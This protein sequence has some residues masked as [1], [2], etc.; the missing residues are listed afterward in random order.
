MMNYI[1]PVSFL[2]EYMPSVIFHNE[3][4]Q[5]WYRSLTRQNLAVLLSAQECLEAWNSAHCK[6]EK[7]INFLPQMK[8]YFREK[9]KLQI[10]HL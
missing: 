8:G 1:V 9:S 3:L 6:N 10:M 2:A 7:I 4:Y 5:T